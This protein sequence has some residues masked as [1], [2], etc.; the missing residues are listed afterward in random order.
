MV[1]SAVV[2]FTV[3][4]AVAP[5]V[6]MIVRRLAI[7]DHPSERSSHDRPTPR[8][9][10][11]AT[12]VG[13]TS[14][15]VLSSQITPSLRLGLVSVALVMGLVGLLDDLMKTSAVTRLGLLTGIAL[16]TAPMFLRNLDISPS[17]GVLAI[18]G[19]ALWLVAFVNAYNF[20]DG[21]NGLAVGQAFV[22][23]TCWAVVG[24]SQGLPSLA[25]GGAIIAAA[26]L[27]FAPYNFPRARMFLGDVGSYFIGA[28]LGA[29][30]IIGLF[31]GLPLE[32]MLAPLL[33]Y[34][35]DTGST[36]AKRLR[37][38]ES[39]WVPHREHAYQ[40]LTAGGWSHVR[41]TVVVVALMSLCAV[42]G[43]FSLR[44]NTVERL[45]ADLALVGVTV[46]YLCLPRAVRTEEGGLGS[47]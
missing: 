9:G 7:I 2:A 14:A 30:A 39:C 24:R 41:T 45:A 17:L 27:A 33:L 47:R 44:A 20:M 29:L 28:W 18:A 16:L 36:L 4:L 11:L 46:G 5:A 42:L 6:L 8:A 23:G 12:V 22:A 35:A 38:R 37:R 43:S 40:R 34:L 19:T 13:V 1:G 25:T 26:A 3:S 15:A 10:G 32:T 21:I 31:A